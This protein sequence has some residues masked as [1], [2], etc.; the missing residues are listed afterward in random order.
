MGI[1]ERCGVY[2][3]VS[4][5]NGR[6][7][8]S[9]KRLDK[10][11]NRYK[12]GSCSKQSAIYASLKKYGYDN[13]KI[14]VLMN[15]KEEDRLFWERVFGDI[16]LSSA[17]HKNGLN[18]LL[19]GYDD[20]PAIVTKEFR[21]K[22]S[23]TQV[24]RFQ[25]P[26][27]RLNT[28][29][30]TKAGF[31][32][33]VKQNMSNIHKSRFIENPELR[34]ERSEVRKDYYKRNP[35][36]KIAASERQKEFLRNNPHIVEI[37]MSGIMEFY[38]NNPTAA[39]EMKKQYFIDNPHKGKEQSIRLKSFYKN[40]PNARLLAAEKTKIQIERNGHNMSKK[41]INTETNEVFNTVK[42]AAKYL[43]LSDTTFRNILKG[44]HKIKLPY[45]YLNS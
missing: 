36:A 23:K 19:P 13:H 35:A 14:T 24:Q 33:E 29:I 17:E 28:S 15:C 21:D 31:T 32:D 11:F 26:N 39:S 1:N 44:R 10:R 7:V 20:I 38:K 45:K 27:Q 34:K 37:Q 25:D 6:Y 12:N 43:S 41:V 18:L 9:S 42:D 8:G 40:N 16:Y 22:I 30:K 5:S 3:I 2:L 4:P